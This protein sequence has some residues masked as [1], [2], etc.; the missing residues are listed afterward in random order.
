VDETEDI[1]EAAGADAA[2][3]DAGRDDRLDESILVS[4][5]AALLSGLAALLSGLAALLSGRR[6]F[7]TEL[8]II[9]YYTYICIAYCKLIV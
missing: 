2:V 6:D 4:G 9:Y 3:A 1:T 7:R 8:D 5:L